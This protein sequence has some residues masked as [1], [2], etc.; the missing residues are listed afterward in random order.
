VDG[1]GR[2][3]CALEGFCVAGCE[4]F[5]GFLWGIVRDDDLYLG[6]GLLHTWAILLAIDRIDGLAV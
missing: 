2:E 5:E 4:L 1:E 3:V 6:S